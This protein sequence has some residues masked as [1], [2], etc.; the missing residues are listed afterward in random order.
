LKELEYEVSELRVALDGGPTGLSRT[1]NRTTS[2]E[3][4]S[5]FPRRTSILPSFDTVG[6]TNQSP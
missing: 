3:R 1:N 4:K 5:G 2:S 6:V